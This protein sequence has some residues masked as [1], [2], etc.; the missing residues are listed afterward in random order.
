MSYLNYSYFDL[1]TEKEYTQEEGAVWVWQ[2]I[3]WASAGEM[4]GSG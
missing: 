2:K 4:R 1:K 3:D